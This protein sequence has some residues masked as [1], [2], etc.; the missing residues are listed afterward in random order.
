M[1]GRNRANRDD[2]SKSSMWFIVILAIVI[3]YSCFT[4]FNQ[5]T[6]L[7]ALN[8]DTDKA[9]ER[10]QR[11]EQMH[12]ALETEMDNLN[13]PEYLEKLA[14]EELGMTRS[15]ELPYIYTRKQQ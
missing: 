12:S 11:A 10:L 15:G 5:Q 14:R 9:T 4:L 8:E 1:A 2:K 3:G 7:N 6:M 13:K